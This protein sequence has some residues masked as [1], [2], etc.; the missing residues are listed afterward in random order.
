M[1]A[2]VDEQFDRKVKPDSLDGEA[3]RVSLL[4]MKS[5]EDEHY[6]IPQPTDCTN[7]SLTICIVSRKL[8]QNS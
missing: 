7:R 2:W 5:Y 3:L 6:A 1:L 4:L 8:A